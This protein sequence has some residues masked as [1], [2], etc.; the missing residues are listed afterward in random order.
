MYF[1]DEN[2][3]AIRSV[4]FD[5]ELLTGKPIGEG[6]EFCSRPRGHAGACATRPMEADLAPHLLDG[7][8]VVRSHPGSRMG[9]FVIPAS[10]VIERRAV[11]STR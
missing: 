4:W 5:C 11:S 7:E 2:G 1:E 3:R 10:T 9:V 8:H 6:H